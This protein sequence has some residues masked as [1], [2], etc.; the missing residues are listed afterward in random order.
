MAKFKRIVLIIGA[1]AMLLAM[2]EPLRLASD[3]W[4]L[5]GYLAEM[6]GLVPMSSGSAEAFDWVVWDDADGQI[7]A[8]YVFPTGP[9]A[10]GG[11]QAGDTFYMLDNIQY[12]T[13]QDLRDAVRGAG[14]GKIK[15]YLVERD[16]AYHD[17]EVRFTRFPTFLYPRSEILWQ[18]A[19][20][21]FAIGAFFHFL[22]LSIAAPLAR[23]SEQARTEF[24]LIAVS[25]LWIVANLARLFSVEM[26]GPPVVGSTYDKVFQGL[27]LLGLVGWIGFPILLLDEVMCGILDRPPS[28]MRSMLAVPPVVFGIAIAAITFAGH[29]G[30]ITL[31]S[32]L[33]PILVYASCYIGASALAVMVVLRSPPGDDEEAE[34]QRSYGGWGLIGS[35]VIFGAAL[36]A[37]LSVQEVVPLLDRLGPV[38]AGWLIVSAQ[39]LAVA[40]VT[41]LS[42]GTLRHGKVDDVLSRTMVYAMVLGLIFFVVVAGFSLLDQYL[43][44]PSYVLSGLFV[45]VLLL[46]FD[47]II[48][49][50]RGLAD[51]VFRTERQRARQLLIEQQERMPDVLDA[52]ELLLDVVSAAGAGL[53]ARS[54]ILFVQFSEPE[55][56]WRSASYHPEPPYLTERVF[57]AIWP[58][59]ESDSRVWARNPELDTRGLPAAVGRELLERGAAL[60]VPIRAKGTSRGLLVLGTKQSRRAVYNLEDVDVLRGLAAHLAVAADRLDLVERE[61]HLARET[62]EAQLVALRSQINP[63]FLFN[64]LNTILSNISEKP[65]TAET[66]VENLAAIFRYTLNAGKLA[67]VTLRQEFELVGHYLDI[68]QARFGEN[69]EV[70]TSIEEGLEQT[71]VPAFCVQ[72]LVENAVK[73]GIER[74]R[75]GGL[76][77][78]EATSTPDGAAVRVSDTGVGIP[79]LFGAPAPTTSLESFYGIGLRN[80][81]ARMELLYG[82]SDL[83]EMQSD[84]ETG[85]VATLRLPSTVDAAVNGDQRPI[86]NEPI[87]T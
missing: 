12:F 14:P 43:G 77:I 65:E 15:S 66:A 61:R 84:P 81:H 9:A 31:E 47:R 69:L 68:E 10:E 41:M 35:M 25:A 74:R 27:T 59:F 16:G 46:V 50:V 5:R 86:S 24:I 56:R 40:P 21:G 60:A 8:R 73:H 70:R 1:A 75:G 57:Q 39:L 54:A 32:L 76:L 17:V 48:R 28:W 53:G 71:L 82:R 4:E 7:E 36:A 37:A 44:G 38:A 45:I 83:L 62:T 42:Y 30:P 58:Y 72:T 64:A 22:A 6:E 67:F 51:A 52:D 19:L 11:L 63:H 55:P 26:L 29:L 87:A 78:V 18:F 80:V 2:V 79:A 33:V 13:I 34:Q 20:W 85:T 23:Q 49:R 3:W